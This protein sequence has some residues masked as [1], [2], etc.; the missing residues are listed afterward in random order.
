MRTTYRQRQLRDMRRTQERRVP[1]RAG[2]ALGK[3]FVLPE[4]SRITAREPGSS[5]MPERFCFGWCDSD[6]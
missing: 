4:P 1:V 3:T 2:Q 6:R 5:E